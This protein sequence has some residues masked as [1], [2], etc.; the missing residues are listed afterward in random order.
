VDLVAAPLVLLVAMVIHPRMDVRETDE[1]WEHTPEY[2][3]FRPV[4]RMR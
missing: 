1:G 4:L 2:E 3:G